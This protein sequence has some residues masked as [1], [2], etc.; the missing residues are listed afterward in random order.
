VKFADKIGH[1]RAS[2][3][4]WANFIRPTFPPP[5]KMFLSPMAIVLINIDGLPWKM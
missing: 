3:N 1:I 5:K 2:E 4:I